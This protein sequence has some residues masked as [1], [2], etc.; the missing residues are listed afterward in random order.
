MLTEETKTSNG[1]LSDSTVSADPVVKWYWWYVVPLWN[2][3]SWVNAIANEM[4]VSK[5]MVGRIS[6]KY[7]D[8]GTL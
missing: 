3:Q 2:H 1:D 8:V 7:L 6:G 4:D 5:L